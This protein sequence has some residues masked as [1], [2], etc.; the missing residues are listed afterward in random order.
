MRP[1]AIE[2]HPT[3]RDIAIQN[4]E[5]IDCGPVKTKVYSLKPGAPT[6]ELAA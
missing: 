5:C 1:A 4:F 6:P 3:R 2:P